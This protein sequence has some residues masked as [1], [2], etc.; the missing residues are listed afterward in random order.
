MA[1]PADTLP[2][3]EPVTSSGGWLEWAR[4]AWM[5]WP[6]AAGVA[7]AVVGAAATR[8]E[9]VATE[10][11]EVRSGPVAPAAGNDD[12]GVEV[13]EVPRSRWAGFWVS[14]RE[15]E[16]EAAPDSGSNTDVETGV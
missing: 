1:A 7:E 9:E 6:T 16:I 11:Q 14:G 12:S 10:L 5:R 15:E 4:P 2:T 13:A 8:A 3:P